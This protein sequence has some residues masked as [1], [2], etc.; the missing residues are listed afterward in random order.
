LRVVRRGPEL[1]VIIAGQN[2][3]L[4]QEDPLAPPPTETAGDERVTAPISGRVARVLALPGDIVEK[5]APLVVIEA[6]KMELTLRA[7][8]SGKIAKVFHDVDEMVEEGTEIVTFMTE[9]GA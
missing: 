3:L 4:I 7:P 8:R 2:Y 1:T 6:M 9:E 5:N